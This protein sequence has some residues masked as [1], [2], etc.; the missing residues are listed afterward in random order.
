MCVNK[1]ML[2][3]CCV[4]AL[5]GERQGFT[6]WE[7]AFFVFLDRSNHLNCVWRWEETTGVF[8]IAL[9]QPHLLL[10][11]AKSTSLPHIPRN[12]TAMIQNVYELPFQLFSEFSQFSYIF[13]CYTLPLALERIYVSVQQFHL[14]CMISQWSHVL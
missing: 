2:L 1:S 14:N 7:A 12:L 3:Q 11:F 10:K 6:C 9:L 13:I 8:Y 4:R 5:P